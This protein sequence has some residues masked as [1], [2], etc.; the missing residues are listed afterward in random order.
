M[1]LGCNR[2]GFKNI[3]SVTR[4]VVVSK[5]SLSVFRRPNPPAAPWSGGQSSL[6][7]CQCSAER[8]HMACVQSCTEHSAIY[9]ML[10]SWKN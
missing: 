5:S 8:P 9:T 1:V 10:Q 4:L 3:S 2:E 6:A 7:F